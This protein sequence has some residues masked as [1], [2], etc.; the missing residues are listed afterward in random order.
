MLVR[1]CGA[2]GAR[3]VVTCPGVGAMHVAPDSTAWPGTAQGPILAS[4][5]LGATA[6][7]G[8]RGR[9]GICRGNGVL[10]EAGM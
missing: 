2:K 5:G 7:S 4:V 6:S 10:G 3:P 9:S 8:W 1:G